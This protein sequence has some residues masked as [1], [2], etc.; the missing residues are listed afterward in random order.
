M[1]TKTTRQESAIDPLALLLR[2]DIY[3]RLTLPDP[4][5]EAIRAQA[6]EAVKG[7]SPRER[8]QALAKVG[9]LVAFARALEHELRGATP[10]AGTPQVR[11]R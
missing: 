4:A 7:L 6:H 10:E 11:T 3:I 9:N 5:P 1:D 8:E 2:S